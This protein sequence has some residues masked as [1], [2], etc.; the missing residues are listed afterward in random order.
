[1]TWP[2]CDL[3]N[4][5]VPMHAARIDSGG[6]RLIDADYRVEKM[7]YGKNGKDKDL[8]TVHYNSRITV[9]DIPR[10]AYDYVV[11][12]KPAIEW[13]MERQVSRQT[14]TAASSTTPTTGR[15]KQ[16]RTRATLWRCCCA[17]SP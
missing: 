16:L 15:R 9:T 6:K 1:M 11:N 7:R 13:V 4:E 10:Q 12:G 3:G 2:S 5:T 17:W 8:S 14:R